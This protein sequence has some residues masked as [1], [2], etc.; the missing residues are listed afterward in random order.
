MLA[1]GPGNLLQLRIWTAKTGWFRSGPVQKP[2]PVTLGSSNTDLYTSARRLHEL[3]TD[4]SIHISGSAFRVSLMIVA[5]RY[6]TVNRKISALVRYWLFV[7]YWP[8]EW[9]KRTE[10]GDLWHPDNKHQRS[11]NDCWLC[12]LGTLGGDRLH[13]VIYNLLAALIGKR[14]SETLPTKCWK[15]ASTECQW[16]LVLHL[17]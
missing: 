1:T 5:F 15:W 6:A 14:E 4:P 13:R 7:M 11:V 3:C 2:D 10:T 17:R 8:P 9:S 12:I 16:F